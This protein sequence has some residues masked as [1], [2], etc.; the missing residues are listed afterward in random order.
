M[1]LSATGHLTVKSVLESLIPRNHSHITKGLTFVR[2]KLPLLH[3][4]ETELIHSN[5]YRC[6][7]S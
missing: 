5:G 6:K 4:K 7:R 1:I 2:A 3:Q